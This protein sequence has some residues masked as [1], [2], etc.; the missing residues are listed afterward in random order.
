MDKKRPAFIPA[1]LTYI[2]DNINSKGNILG[3]T[4]EG[5]AA[6]ASDIEF[7]HGS[8]TA[9]FAGCGYQYSAMLEPL[10][11]LVRSADR[12]TVDPDLPV[13]LAGIPR[14]LGIDVARLF[15][16]AMS[17]RKG[18]DENVLRDAVTVLKALGIELSYLGKEEPC[19]GAPLYQTG[20]HREYGEVANN[21]YRKLKGQGIKRVIGLVPSCMYALCNLSPKFVDG[22][23]IEVK[24]FIEIVDENLAMLNLRYPQRVNVAY[25]DPCQLGRYMGILEQPRR[26]LRSIQNIELVEPEWTAGQWST[27]CG[28]GGG[29]EVVFPGMSLMLA[30]N[31]ARELV[32][33]GAGIIATHCP[34]CLMQLKSGVKA[35]K[36]V[37]VEVLDLATLIAR[38]LPQNNL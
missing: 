22:Y 10:V 3:L 35:L 5:K 26:V 37:Q 36:N 33:T 24:H 27:C 18:S 23:D 28:G 13:V 30:A 15:S 32:S 29:F 14:K 6:W 20:L 11:N 2:A 19:C 17:N 7:K 25:H 34:G 21:A 12:M 9:F 38:A 16:A 1:G 4:P 8:P 31:R